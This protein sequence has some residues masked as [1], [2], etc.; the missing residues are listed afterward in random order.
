MLNFFFLFAVNVKNVKEDSKTIR[1]SVP[2]SFVLFRF[3]NLLT[4]T[5]YFYKGTIRYEL[6]GIYPAQEFFA[7]NPTTGSVTVTRD[8][9]TD[10]FETMQYTVSRMSLLSL[11]TY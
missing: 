1:P 7:V 4:C 11:V 10:S 2:F 8:L 9:A 5:S 6:V 3:Y